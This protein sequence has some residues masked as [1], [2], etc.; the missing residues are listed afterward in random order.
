MAAVD[1]FSFFTRLPYEIR[2]KIWEAALPAPRIVPV[3]Y[4][5]LCKQYTSD[6]PPPAL[7]H[8][9]TESRR[10]FLSVYENFR[11]SQKFDSSIFVDFAR[12]TIFFDNL[13]CSPEGD[14]ASDLAMS[15][16]SQKVLYCAID[17][18][19]WEVLRVFRYDNLSEVKLLRRL[20]TLALV[21]RQDYDRGLR[22]TRMTHDGREM[23]H[24]DVVDTVGSEIQHVHFNV[25]SIRAEL[26][27]EKDPNWEGGPPNVQ[28]WII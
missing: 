16:Q 5:R 25:E 4:N 24:V 27:H 23:V 20:R 9:C 10:V 21:L 6:V 1:N 15:P 19:L 14:L 3:R 13:D 2:L 17:A 26:E 18:Q 12:D 7:L 8:A 28:M 22:Q 11:L